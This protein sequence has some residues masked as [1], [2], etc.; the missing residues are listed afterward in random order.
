ML[1]TYCCS[2]EHVTK[3]CPDLL[4]KWEDKKGNCNMVHIEPGRPPSRGQDQE[5]PQSPPKFDAAQQ[6]QF[7]CDAHQAL[8]EERAC[9]E[10]QACNV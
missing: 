10:L 5:A 2:L 3:D 9:E 8:D 7:L 1:C 6:K 4:K